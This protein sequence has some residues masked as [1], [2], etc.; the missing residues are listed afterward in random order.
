MS[1]ND[2]TTKIASVL[3]KVNAL[4][5]ALDTSD[6][7][8]AAKDIVKDKTAYVNGKKVTGTRNKVPQITGDVTDKY[9]AQAR[10]LISSTLN[11]SV[12]ADK[13]AGIVLTMGAADLGNAADADVAKGKTYTSASGFKR[14]G[15]HEEAAAPSGSINITENGTY[16]VTDKASAVVNVPSTAASPCV[17]DLGAVG[18]TAEFNKTAGVVGIDGELTGETVAYTEFTSGGFTAPDEWYSDTIYGTVI[19]FKIMPFNG[20]TESLAVIDV[21]TFYNYNSG[22]T[23]Y[24]GE[25]SVGM[26]TND[27]DMYLIGGCTDY[28]NESKNAFF[29]DAPRALMDTTT[30]VVDGTAYWHIVLL[31]RDDMLSDITPLAN[32]AGSSGNTHLTDELDNAHILLIKY[33]EEETT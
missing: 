25:M 19:P 26:G 16:D 7:T 24:C 20:Q 8:A 10:V 11:K 33:P 12:A 27:S 14:T 18:F 22:N 5:E 1:L 31:I 15:T 23:T 3:A 17:I 9:I 32:N 13:G 2:N 30:S 4:P 29:E 6:A 21:R 28:F